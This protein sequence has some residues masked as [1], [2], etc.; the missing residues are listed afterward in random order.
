M[1]G[2]WGAD[3]RREVGGRGTSADEEFGPRRVKIPYGAG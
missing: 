2:A 3:R 1:V